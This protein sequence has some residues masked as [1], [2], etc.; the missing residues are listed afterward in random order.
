MKTTCSWFMGAFVALFAAAA[1]AESTGVRKLVLADESRA[2]LHYYDTSDPAKCFAIPAV[3]PVWDLKQVGKQ[4]F[5]TV[6]G[7]GFQIFDLEQRK[8]VDTFK[9]PKLNGVSA[10]CDLKDG[11]F[12]ASVNLGRYPG[13]QVDFVRFNAKREYVATYSSKALFNIR[14][15]E[16]DSDG[17]TLLASWQNGCMRLKLVDADHSV[18][19]LSDYRQ[20]HGKNA[21]DYKRALNGKDYLFSGGYHGGVMRITSEGKTLSTWFMP[22]TKDPKQVER[23]YAQ[24]QEMK[25]GSVYVAHWTGHGAKDSYTGWQVVQFAQDGSLRWGLH[26]PDR[27]GSVSGVIVLDAPEMH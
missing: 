1:V 16:L 6:G 24:L 17:E 25:D 7:G 4:K 19:V 26:D 27:L 20:P 3:K 23:F 12:V 15:M 22:K 9:H 18:K 8:V 21:F 2:K 13:N 14:T 11:G 10:M 5:R